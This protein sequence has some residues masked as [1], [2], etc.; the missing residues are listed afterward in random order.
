MRGKVP[1]IVEQIKNADGV[2]VNT[3][4]FKDGVWEDSGAVDPEYVKKKRDEAM[5]RAV[6]AIGGRLIE[7]AQPTLTQ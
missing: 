2:W 4:T 1:T 6:K 3:G 7:D 5:R